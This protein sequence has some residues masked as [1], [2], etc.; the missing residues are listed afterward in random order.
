MMEWTRVACDNHRKFAGTRYMLADDAMMSDAWTYAAQEY[1]Y[2]SW[3]ITVER[4]PGEFCLQTKND[5][6]PR[7]FPDLLYNRGQRISCARADASVSQRT[8]GGTI[9]IF[10]GGVWARQV[11]I[12]GM[13][14]V[15]RGRCRS[16]ANASDGTARGRWRL[17]RNKMLGMMRGLCGG[18]CKEGGAATSFSCVKDDVK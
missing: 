13:A 17:V 3:W 12:K 5:F 14:K 18:K 11:E 8:S 15:C 2:G 9:C 7:Y 6:I 10:F 4:P 1:Q 16:G